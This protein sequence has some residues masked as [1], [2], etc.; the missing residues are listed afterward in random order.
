ML[1]FHLDEHVATAIAT[2]LRQHGIDVSTSADANLS[3][4][5][6]EDHL[7]HAL[8]QQRVIVT[9]DHDFLRLNAA[10]ASHAGIAY[11]HQ[12]KYSIGELLS[13]L[14]LMDACYTADDMAGHVEYL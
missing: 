10:G 7:R 4:A 11:C 13:L 1:T 9:H 8:S 12:D 3:G 14:L 5:E 2:A 6:D